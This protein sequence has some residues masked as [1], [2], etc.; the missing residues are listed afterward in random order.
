MFLKVKTFDDLI[1]LSLEKRWLSKTPIKTDI[2]LPEIKIY[3][4]KK[5]DSRIEYKKIEPIVIHNFTSEQLDINEN[6]IVLGSCLG[7]IHNGNIYPFGQYHSHNW[8]TGNQIKL[9]SKNEIYVKLRKSSLESCLDI[10]YNFIG[11]LTHWGHFFV[12][13]IDRI[14]SIN[15]K[16]NLILSDTN[17]FNTYQNDIGTNFWLKQVGDLIKLLGINIDKNSKLILKKDKFYEFNKIK[18]I[19]LSSKKPSIPANIFK[20]IQDQINKTYEKGNKYLLYVGRA[21]VNKRKVINQN[22]IT[23][24]IESLGGKVIFPEKNNLN[25]SI[26]IFHSSSKIILVLGSSMFN[27]VF[28]MPGTHIVCI[29]PHGYSNDSMNSLAILRHMCVVLNLILDIYEVKSLGSSKNLLNLDLILENSDILN[30]IQLFNL[31]KG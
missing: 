15:N 28:C 30:I 31:N 21:D 9:I 19:T 13:T 17:I 27:L 29:V 6:V 3:S 4:N 1:N 22:Q 2:Y 12:D 16:D 10:P 20:G 18:M 7:L 26:Q 25:S 14:F 5:F 8:F 23:D 11:I 24:M